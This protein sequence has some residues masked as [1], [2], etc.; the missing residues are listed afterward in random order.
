MNGSNLSDLCKHLTNY[1][2]NKN[3]ED[4]HQ[5]TS[6][7]GDDGAHKRLVTEVMRDLKAEGANTELLWQVRLQC[8][9]RA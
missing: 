8:L 3:A 1:A 9:R 2:I 7:S 5:P 6:A 4:F